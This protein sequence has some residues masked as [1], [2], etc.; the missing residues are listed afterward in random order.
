MMD[1]ELDVLLDILKEDNRNL[2]RD[3][4]QCPEF[5]LTFYKEVFNWQLVFPITGESLI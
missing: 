5:Q 3:D 2:P 1:T 4:E